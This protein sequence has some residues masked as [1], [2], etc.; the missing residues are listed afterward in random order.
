MLLTRWNPFSLRREDEPRSARGTPRDIA[1]V[2][3]QASRE[4][5]VLSAQ[6]RRLEQQSWN[7]LE[8]L[9]TELRSFKRK[10]GVCSLSIHPS[11]CLS[12]CLSLP[13]RVVEYGGLYVRLH[14]ES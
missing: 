7:E 11:I 2:L 8:G 6:A 4:F 1:D 14:R 10:R 3:D 13:R 5:K 9:R 12:V